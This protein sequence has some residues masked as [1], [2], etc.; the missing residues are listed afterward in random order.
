MNSLFQ[1]SAFNNSISSL[2]HTNVPQLY[3]IKAVGDRVRVNENGIQVIQTNLPAALIL[4]GFMVELINVTFTKKKANY[5]D[6]CTDFWHSGAVLSN[7]ISKGVAEIEI[8]LS[9]PGRYYICFQTNS[10]ENKTKVVKQWFHQGSNYHNTL[11]VA[12][13]L[14]PVPLQVSSIILC[15]LLSGIFSGLN[16]GLMSL[17]LNEIQVIIRCGTELEKQYAKIIEP[18]RKQGNFLLCAILFGKMTSF[19]LIFF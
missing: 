9:E 4:F 6:D 12:N 13:R 5:S 1:S 16:L 3:G 17:D 8:E 15:L 10:I 11:I 18:I 7:T 14:M 19:F 2:N